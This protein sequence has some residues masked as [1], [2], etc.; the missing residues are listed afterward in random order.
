MAGVF[1]REA[2][3]QENVAQVAI[4]VG[5]YNLRPATVGIHLPLYRSFNLVI[6]TGPSAI[7]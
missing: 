1:I 2:F 6:K 4:T 5:T 7:A 3:P